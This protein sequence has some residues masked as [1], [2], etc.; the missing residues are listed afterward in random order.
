VL[1]RGVQG[2]R[3]P[4]GPARR[5]GARHVAAGDSPALGTRQEPVGG[6]LGPR[7]QRGVL[8]AR[9]LAPPYL[10]APAGPFARL[11]GLDPGGRRL[12]KRAGCPRG[13]PGA[14][15]RCSR[16]ARA[17]APTGTAAGARAGQ[18]RR[19]AAAAGFRERA[20]IGGVPRQAPARR[21]PT[22]ATSGAPNSRAPRSPARKGTG[23][24]AAAPRG[25][26]PGVE[27]EAPGQPMAPQ[28]KPSRE[29]P[30][31]ATPREPG[32]TARAP[33]GRGP[34]T[35]ARL[36]GPMAEPAGRRPS[37][38]A[39]A[40]SRCSERRTEG[41]VLSG[42]RGRTPRTDGRASGC[43]WRR[44]HCPRFEPLL[45]YYRHGCETRPI[46]AESRT[47]ADPRRGR[48]INRQLCPRKTTRLSEGL[49]EPP[50]RDLRGPPTSGRSW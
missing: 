39:Y 3:A 10:L 31:G 20:R 42:A 14:P 7:R 9:F 5:T 23:P 2:R 18:T 24:R 38:P 45:S 32:H 50:N 37:Y 11:F 49:E 17:V 36:R 22:W 12:T 27:G 16:A 48:P 1:V 41:G 15:A 8:A 30:R 33:S 6:R 25:A 43:P 13:L 46:T 35:G 4:P 29:P 26:R 47:P 44:V 19:R 21:G 34:E 40:P 28:G